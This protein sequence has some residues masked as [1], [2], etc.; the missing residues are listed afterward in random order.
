MFDTVRTK[1]PESTLTTPLI[2]FNNRA[3]FIVPLF[4]FITPA[5]QLYY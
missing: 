5:Q 3:I 4:K 1:L 2:A